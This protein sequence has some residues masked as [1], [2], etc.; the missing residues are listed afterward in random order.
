M[1]ICSGLLVYWVAR[2]WLLLFGAEEEIVETLES[3]LTWGRRLLLGLRTLFVPP[4]QL[5]G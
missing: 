3:D 5:A 2:T 1:F 4:A